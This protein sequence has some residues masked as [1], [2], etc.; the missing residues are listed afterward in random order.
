MKKLAFAAA[1][2]LA[3]CNQQSPQESAPQAVMAPP[4]A[5]SQ[6]ALL[7]A[8]VGKTYTDFVQAPGMQRYAASGLGFAES[9][10]AERFDRNMQTL[11]PS[12]VVNGND[13][14]A[15]VFSGC[16]AHAC[17]GESVGVLAIDLATGDAF[18]GVK[19]ADGETVL[20]PNARL[21]MLLTQTSPTHAWTDP[22]AG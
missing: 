16:M 10:A 12:V 21:Q 15:L 4:S 1:L 5:V 13:L 20:K 2:L 7:R 11:F 19:D 6:T 9:S 3:A 14:E 18:V 17:G 22:P 8:Q